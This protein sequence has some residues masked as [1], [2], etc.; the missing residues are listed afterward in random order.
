V[1]LSPVN[2]M[3]NRKLRGLA[4]MRICLASEHANR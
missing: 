3:V 4:L 1:R 2:P